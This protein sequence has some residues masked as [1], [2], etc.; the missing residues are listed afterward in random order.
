MP[1]GLIPIRLLTRVAPLPQGGTIRGSINLP[2]QSLPLT[3]P[4]VYA[5]F[6][7]AGLR[8]VIFYC[9]SLSRWHPWRSPSRLR[10]EADVRRIIHGPWK[11]GDGLAG[12]PHCQRRRQ[13]YEEPRAAGRHQGM[14]GCWGRVCRVDGRV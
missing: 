11:P 10:L 2:A 3:L 12:G 14:G 7:T 9:G 1:S 4:S 5:M 13:G 6:K 8:K